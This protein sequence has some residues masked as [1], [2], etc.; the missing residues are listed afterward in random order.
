MMTFLWGLQD[1]CI[2]IHVE[3][4]LG[5]EFESNKEPFSIDCLLESSMVFAFQM[6]QSIIETRNQKLIYISVVGG[7]GFLMCSCTLFFN[8]KQR[9]LPENERVALEYKQIEK[10]FIK[11]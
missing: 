7:L 1:S 2:S 6:V 8:F 3:T 11:K 10:N 5:F 9:E 4:I